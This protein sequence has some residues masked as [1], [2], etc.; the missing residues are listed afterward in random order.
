MRVFALQEKIASLSTPYFGL[1]GVVLLAIP[2]ALSR[3][4]YVGALATLAVAVLIVL[5]ASFIRIN[6]AKKAKS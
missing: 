2:V 4:S 6:N 1:I 3:F 5:P